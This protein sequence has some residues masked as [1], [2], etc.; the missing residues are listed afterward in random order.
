MF[1]IDIEIQITS[2]FA[3]TFIETLDVD[4]LDIANIEFTENKAQGSWRE[5]RVLK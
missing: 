5:A 1:W 4:F 3:E 2:L